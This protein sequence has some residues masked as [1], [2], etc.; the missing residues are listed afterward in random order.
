MQ[1]HNAVVLGASGL[2]AQRMQQRLANHPWFQLKAV[3]G[4][5]RTAGRT[6]D[7]IDWKLPEKKPVLP[8]LTVLDA[9]DENIVGQLKD[10]GIS[11]AFSCIPASIADPLELAL[12]SSGI[13][14]FSNASAFRRCD[15]IPLVIPD[16]NSDHLEHF[17]VAGYPL[18]CATNCTLIPLAVPAAALARMFGIRHVKMNS[19]QALSGAGYELVLDAQALS[20][21]HPSEIIG[22]AEKTASELLH[23]LGTSVNTQRD[24]ACQM[25]VHRD[26]QSITESMSHVIAMNAEVEASCRR[27]TRIDGHQ[28]FASIQLEQPTTLDEVL[29][30]L[31]NWSPPESL[32]ECPSAPHRS[33]HIVE[34]IDVE[35]HLWSNGLEFQ[36]QPD[37]SADLKAGMAVVIG[38][39]RMTSPTCVEFSAYSHNTVRGAAGGTMWLAEQAYIQNRLSNHQ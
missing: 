25:G 30:C 23:V 26:H 10:A 24:Q 27:V 35:Q 11:V 34:H 13:A 21:N 1:R 39:V 5:Q 9:E 18:A 29:S 22:E 14:V 36:S 32:R 8:N 16:V 38:S 2:V 19:E 6:L 7:S 4:S 12:A 3:V 15:G 17:G 28:I 37:P 33:L 20:G 31:K